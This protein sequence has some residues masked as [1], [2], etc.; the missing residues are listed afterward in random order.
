MGKIV[1][2]GQK[3]TLQ[4][5]SPRCYWS[6]GYL[7]WRTCW[8]VCRSLSVVNRRGWCCC[9]MPKRS[10]AKRNF[11]DYGDNGE[12]KIKKSK[13]GASSSTSNLDEDLVR[14]FC[15]FSVMALLFTFSGIRGKLIW[16]LVQHNLT[17]SD[18]LEWKKRLIHEEANIFIILLS[19]SSLKR[20]HI[21][22]SMIEGKL[23]RHMTR[24]ALASNVSIS[25]VFLG[26]RTCELFLFFAPF[27]FLRSI[28]LIL[29]LLCFTSLVSLTGSYPENEPI[30]IALKT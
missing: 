8:V 18:F 22:F 21:P 26:V 29:C 12:R 17:S 14:S 24:S 9:T 7:I 4:Y 30:K 19:W 25:E 16:F 28:V 6:I 3:M 27:V 15:L 5:S 2:Q 1:I 11:R 20:E 23:P 10:P 13:E